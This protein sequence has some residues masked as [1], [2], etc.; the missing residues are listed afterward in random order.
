MV[1]IHNW[2]LANAIA[3]G[4]T[5]PATNSHPEYPGTRASASSIPETS[6]SP[7]GC[8]G[9]GQIARISQYCPA[10]SAASQSTTRSGVAIRR[11]IRQPRAASPWSIRASDSGVQPGCD[12]SDMASDDT[13]LLWLTCH[14]NR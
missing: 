5:S 6:A 7:M 12:V 9:G 8:P 2:S 13:V 1:D 3:A 11:R 4:S 10:G 14:R